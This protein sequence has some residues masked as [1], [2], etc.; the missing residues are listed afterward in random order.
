MN[1]LYV[2]AFLMVPATALAQDADQGKVIYD[3]WCAGCHG[4]T[5]AG[6][7]EA[8]AYMLPRPRDFTG[9]IYQIRTTASGELP[10]DDD[11][12][13]VI[14]EGMPGTT[15]P[16]WRGRLSGGQRDDVI[17]YLK[18]F[19]RF[20]NGVDPEPIAVGRQPGS[21]SEEDLVEARRLFD[22]E[23]QC[24][25]CHGNLGRADGR[26]APELTDD[27]G[28]PIRAADLTKNWR[29]NGGGTVEDIY[30]RMRTGLD[31]TPMPSNNDVVDAGIITDEQLWRVAQ[32]VRS[33]APER[34]PVRRDVIR[35]ARFEGALPA[36]PDDAAWD[37]VDRYY[38][39][40]VGQIT[41]QP[42][43]FTPTVDDIWVQAA[44]DGRTLA[45]KV[46]WNDPTQSPDPA[47]DPFFQGIVQ[48]LTDVDGPHLS[49][50]GPDRLG[51]QFPITPPEGT[52]LPFFL[53]GDT[54]RPVYM[55]QWTS[56]PD[57]VAE[58]TATGL[59]TFVANSGSSQVSHAVAFSEGQWQV[60][61]SRSLAPADSSVAVPFTPG[62]SLPIAFY[63]ADGTDAEDDVR[64]SVSAWFAIYL[65]VPTPP[66]VFVVPF[67]VV[68]VTAGLGLVIVRQ[69]QRSERRA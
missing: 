10:T 8:A 62:E 57:R 22:D 32:Y 29:F 58:G 19:S 15:M 21:P 26:S 45:V 1:R 66:S 12:R 40:M 61:F 6:D 37:D 67:V 33:M 65:D 39:P 9:A 47:W 68:F 35:A 42:R 48:T 49:A 63:A 46:T 38:I 56:S 30:I 55:W 13:R 41:I 2:L 17:A 53:G 28:F 54:Q 3:K 14:D 50:Q 44:H 11:M 4:D 43:W 69:A 34:A 25:R 16:A 27:G 59:G 18:T 31:G 52:E 24:L 7:G 60:Q 36:G 64:G 51:V 20:F 23:L 5:G